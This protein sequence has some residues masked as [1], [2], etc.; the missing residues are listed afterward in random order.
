MKEFD[1]EIEK[2]RVIYNE[3]PTETINEINKAIINLKNETNEDIP[4][5][6]Y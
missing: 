6:K 1:S 4:E 2:L 5:K 3:K